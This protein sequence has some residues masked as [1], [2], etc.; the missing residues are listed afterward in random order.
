MAN[1]GVLPEEK[2]Q[3]Q[4]IMIDLEFSVNI[5]KAAARDCV[6]DTIDYAAVKAA[7][8]RVVEQQHYNLLETLAD[9]LAKV[10][11]KQ[12]AFSWLKLSIS[13]PDIFPD[14]E[15]VGVVVEC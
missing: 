13:K 11:R 12:F 15:V 8:H 4:S 2:Q 6:E 10:L 14:M 5:A 1:I 3:A 7:I 9:K